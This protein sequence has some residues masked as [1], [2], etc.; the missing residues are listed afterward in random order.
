MALVYYGEFDAASDLT[1]A[2]NIR[3][4]ASHAQVAV[5]ERI[6]PVAAGIIAAT[7]TVSQAAA[8]G[9][10]Q[11]IV[12]ANLVASRAAASGSAL[13]IV[14][15]AGVVVF[16]SAA[17]GGSA[18]G[19]T[20]FSETHLIPV[21]GQSNAVGV[22]ASPIAPGS[23]D[24]LPNLFAMP[25]QGAG[26]GTLVQA[27]EPL[28]HPVTAPQAN[29][30]GFAFAFARWYALQH[31][32]VRV[33]LV[34][35]AVSGTGFRFSSPNTYSWA[36]GREGEAGITNLY[37][38]AINRVA[39]AAALVG[40]T[41]KV[42]AIL[43]HQMEADAVGGITAGQYAADLDALIAGFRMSMPNAQ[44]AVFL[45]GQT[46]W[47]FRNVRRPGTY[48][49]LDGVL[50]STPSRV[51]RTGFAPAPGQGYANSDNTHFTGKG[52]WLLHKAYI[53]AYESALYN[54]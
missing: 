9:V 23:A 33:V 42:P 47:E 44:D 45:A 38:A 15:D 26:A 51:T 30:R 27:S 1:T 20:D 29:T 40:G 6:G 2:A 54:I 32:D 16:T 37:R 31:P 43:W 21:T 36:P 52:Q 39:A 28:A 53:E 8:A 19:D 5:E 35:C 46:V 24:Q 10:A 13:E 50:Q 4:T 41:V 49:Q 12:N 7:P 34:P 48:A 11:A 22:L 17:S 25:A 3:R 14:D 18:G